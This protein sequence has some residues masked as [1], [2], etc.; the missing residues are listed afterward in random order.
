MIR[1]IRIIR[2]PYLYL[3]YFALAIRLL[4][5]KLYGIERSTTIATVISLMPV[6]SPMISC[7]DIIRINDKILARDMSRR[8]GV[9][10]RGKLLQVFQLR[11]LLYQSESILLEQLF[12]SNQCSRT[13]APKV[14]LI[15]YRKRARLTEQNIEKQAFH[16]LL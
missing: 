15:P 5:D 16:I 6:F 11:S 1:I 10:V 9:Y 4:R 2:A 7:Y 14:R 13:V 12:L 3:E 8:I